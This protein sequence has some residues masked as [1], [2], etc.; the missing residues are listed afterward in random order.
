MY[1]QVQKIG[2]LYKVF[3]SKTIKGHKEERQ[4]RLRSRMADRGETKLLKMTKNTINP[5]T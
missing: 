4:N 3:K 1:T 5:N 2:K